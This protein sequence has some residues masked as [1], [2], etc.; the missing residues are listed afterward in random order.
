MCFKRNEHFITSKYYLL[1]Y[2]NRYI[3]FRSSKNDEEYL[4]VDIK[5]DKGEI[6]LTITNTVTNHQEVLNNPATGIYKFPL[7]KGTR[8]KV[9][10]H[11]YE[12]YG[13][14]ILKRIRKDED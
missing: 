5:N 3:S 9:E 7:I 1:A 8:Y 6:N 4:F 13:H 14:Y 2:T 10:I 12:A 11:S